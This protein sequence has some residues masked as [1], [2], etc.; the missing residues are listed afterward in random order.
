[1]PEDCLNTLDTLITATTISSK[2]INPS[3]HDKLFKSSEEFYET[4]AVCGRLQSLDL[5]DAVDSIEA[6]TVSSPKRPLISPKP[7]FRP[8]AKF[9]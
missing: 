5:T 6:V 3:T 1:M 9:G 2:P 4:A 8:S 7:I